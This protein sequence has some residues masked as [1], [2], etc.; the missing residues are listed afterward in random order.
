MT[1]ATVNQDHL[2]SVVSIASWHRHHI[3]GCLVAKGE[4]FGVLDV[5]VTVNQD[6]V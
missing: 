1:H 3:I 2:K 5:K 6:H 4:A